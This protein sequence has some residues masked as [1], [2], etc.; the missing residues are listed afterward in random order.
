MNKLNVILYLALVF[1][2]IVLV[3]DAAFGKKK[4]TP[5]AIDV[6]HFGAVDVIENGVPHYAADRDE[7]CAKHKSEASCNECCVKNGK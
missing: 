4:P 6:E 5:E 1:A 2:A 3:A 7:P